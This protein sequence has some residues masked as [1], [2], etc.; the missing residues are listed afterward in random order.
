MKKLTL[1]FL[2]FIFSLNLISQEIYLFNNDSLN[3]K[4]RVNQNNSL[5]KYINE[6]KVNVCSFKVGDTI[7]LKAISNIS[8][9]YAKHNDCNGFISDFHFET[10]DYVRDIKQ[11]YL[12][13]Y[14]SIRSVEIQKRDK[15]EKVLREEKLLS[16][17]N[18]CDYESN[19][20]DT[21][22]GKSIKEIVYYDITDNLNLLK[23]KIERNGNDF[24]LKILTFYDLGCSIPYQSN[25]S[26]ALIKLENGKILTFFHRGNLNCSSFYLVARITPSEI[27][28]LKKSKI[29]AI[30]LEG[31]K[32]YRDFEEIVYPTFFQD[33]LKC[34]L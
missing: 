18:K 7:T 5:F 9:F 17:R 22:T 6:E 20:I 30:R 14:D 31:T 12:N 27:N 10:N 25:Q 3:I 26:K 34:I 32:Y 11:L 33:K 21:F 16:F 8:T 24:F 29:K 4:V 28:D 23:M 15:R 19:K 2:F 13:N 1:S